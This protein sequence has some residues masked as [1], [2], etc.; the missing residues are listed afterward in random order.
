[1]PCPSLSFRTQRLR[2]VIPDGSVWAT[3]GGSPRA[4]ADTQ[5]GSACVGR[6]RT[7]FAQG[8]LAGIERAA[9]RPT[10]APGPWPPWLG[11]ARSA[12]TASGRATAS[13]RIGSAPSR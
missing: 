13:G 2:R 9:P 7:R 11:S 10:G 5:T 8:G 3:P 6:S 4:T 1:M 12:S